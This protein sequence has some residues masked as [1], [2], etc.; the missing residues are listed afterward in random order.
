M[1]KINNKKIQKYFDNWAKEYNTYL[2]KLPQYQ[3]LVKSILEDISD[4][5]SN[6]NILEAGIGTG[7]LAF[8]IYNRTKANIIGI[9]FSEEMIKKCNERSQAEKTNFDLRVQN[10]TEY[11]VINNYFDAIISNLTLHH[12]INTEKQTLISKV[13]Q[14]LKPGGKFILG[15][16]IID[17]D[18]NPANKLWLEHVIK[19]WRYAAKIALKY[20]G[21]SAAAIELDNMSKVYLKNFEL[22]NT[23]QLWKKYL[24]NAGFKNIKF[25]FINKNTG[26]CK[27]SAEKIPAYRQAGVV[28]G[29]I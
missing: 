2:P 10:L 9:D 16:I 8:A 27:I 23:F 6:S 4:L 5:D 18:G 22:M 24:Q 14:S 17:F 3:K 1:K 15:E 7:C 28:K 20:A 25:K 12:L 29:S 21:P 26:W 19:R 13:Y 11:N